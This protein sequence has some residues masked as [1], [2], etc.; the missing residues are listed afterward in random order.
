MK[1][2][3]RWRTSAAV[4]MAAACVAA[5]AVSVLCGAPPRMA[6]QQAMPVVQ[7]QWQPQTLLETRFAAKIAEDNKFLLGKLNDLSRA[8]DEMSEEAKAGWKK[9][10]E[11]T[12]LSNPRL[13]VDGN[14]HD[15]LDNILNAL[16]PI[17]KGSVTISIDAASAIIEYKEHAG[18]EK[19]KDI[20]AVAN[21]RVTFS[22]SPGGMVLEGTLCHSRLCPII[23]CAK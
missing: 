4:I 3:R 22:A 20:D 12:F 8:S 1:V 2:T 18:K 7:I 13:W 15:G 21:V 5:A 10:F 23:P 6:A 19:D 11:N 9:G 17:V 14:W 16:K